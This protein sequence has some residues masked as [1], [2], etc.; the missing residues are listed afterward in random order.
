MIATE[1]D[2]SKPTNP[3]YWC[4]I[5]YRHADNKEEGRQWATWLH[6]AIETYEVPEDLAGTTNERGDTI[7]QRIFPVFRDE[8]ELPADA[9]L[10][11]PIYRALDATRF[12]IVICSPRVV[13]S[14]YVT[15]E[16]RYFKKLGGEDRVL[17]VMVEGEPNTSRD[18]G[19]QA[20]GFR[21]EDEC[22]PDALRHG[23]GPDGTTLDELT[24]PVAADFRLGKEQ[25]WTSPEA[26][27]QAMRRD[28]VLSAREI[29]RRV[30][31]YRQRSHLMLLKILAGILGVPLGRLTQRDKAYQLAKAQ[32]RARLARRIAAGFAVLALAAVAAAGIAL[33]QYRAAEKSKREAQAAAERATHARHEAEKLV[34]FMVFDLRDKLQPIGR[35][36]LLDDVNHKVDEYYRAFGEQK[37][38]LTVRR[39][40]AVAITN[41][42]NVLGCQVRQGLSFAMRSRKA[43]ERSRS[44]RSEGSAV[45]RARSGGESPDR[46]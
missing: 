7:P 8:E 16:I 30:E 28:D 29:E 25:G 35:L 12:L 10:S 2:P 20:M 11:S 18:A 27:R 15:E 14:T 38:D 5:S 34:E 41:A 32:R 31:E 40:R 42:G 21:A 9:D 33:V 24:E 44:G 39:Q 6:H 46:S 19:K 45:C 1:I 22:F 43:R 26:Y 13:G 4:F 37:M 3:R 23:V 36:D 17:A